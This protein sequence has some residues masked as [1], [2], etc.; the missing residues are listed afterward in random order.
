MRKILF[1]IFIVVL[2]TV[3]LTGCINLVLNTDLSEYGN[4][5]K[6]EYSGL[7]VEIKTTANNVTLTNSFDVDFDGEKS[8]VNYSIESLNKLSFESNEEHYKKV[9]TGTV[10]VEGDKI[11]QVD[12]ETVDYGFNKIT[13]PS[14]NFSAKVENVKITDTQVEFDVEDAKIF[15]RNNSFDGKDLKFSGTVGNN[16]FESIKIT[17]ETDDGAQ[18]E[19]IYTFKA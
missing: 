9:S 12:G 13:S 4:M 11:T 2:L 19:L 15:M 14:F 8:T 16:K 5:L 6:T 7:K 17:Y 1:A 10:V 18:V 3:C